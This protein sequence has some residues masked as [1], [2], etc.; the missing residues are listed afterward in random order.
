[1]GQ[2][3]VLL[4]LGGLDDAAV[5][6]SEVALRFGVTRQTVH[7][8]LRRYAERGLV[9][10]QV[11][12]TTS[13]VHGRAQT[14][15]GGVT[16]SETGL[17]TA[18]SAIT[19]ASKDPSDGAESATTSRTAPLALA[20]TRQS[21]SDPSADQRGPPQR[22]EPAQ[23]DP[24]DHRSRRR[25]GHGQIDRVPTRQPGVGRGRSC[26]ESPVS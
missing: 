22:I 12:R 4:R 20:P 21:F 6:V 14:P 16:A 26:V 13:Q 10:V 1:M 23:P 3:G 15:H 9:R 17:S 7:Q 18:V 5:A 24:A 25:I 19:T 11:S 8:W 2:L